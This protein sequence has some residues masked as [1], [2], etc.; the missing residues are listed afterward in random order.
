MAARLLQASAAQTRI[1]C[2]LEWLASR[3]PGEEILVL[4]A[5]ADAANELLRSAA[6][7]RGAAFGWHRGTLP[8]LAAQLAAEALLERGAVPVGRLA[9]QAVVAHVLHALDASG[10]AGR[11]AALREGPGLA[12]ALTA[13]LDELRHARVDPAALE[14]E[15][16]E[17]RAVCD[18]YAAALAAAGLADR[19]DVF[20]LAARRARAA[21]PHALL[22][23]PT[24]L[25]DVALETPVEAAL[26]AALTARSPELLATVPAGD[27]AS[28]LALRD[29]LGVDV[30]A[31]EPSGAIPASLA[32]LQAHLF[33]DTAPSQLAL[34]EEIALLSAP[35]ESRECVE[36]ARR[37]LGLA[38][39]GVAFDRIAILLR[40]PEEYRPHLV[41]AL[42]RAGIPAHFARGAQHPDAAGRAFLALLACAAEGLSARR[43]AEYLSLGEVPDPGSGGA[44]P[45]A[46]PPG[47]RWV[48]PDTELLAEAVAEALESATGACPEPEAAPPADADAPVVAGDLRAPRRWE[49]LLVDAAVIGGRERWQRRIDGLARELALDLEALE[50]PDDPAAERIRRSLSDLAHLRAYALPLLDALTALPERARWSAWLDRLAA[51]AT[52]ALRRPERVLAVL[53]EL[54]PMHEVGPVDLAEVRLVLARRLL[55]LAAPPASARYGRVFVAPADAARGLCFD[56]VFVPGLA[57]KLFPRKIQEEPLLLDA[58]RARLGSALAV[59]ADRVA[60]ERRALRLAV[61]AASK[62]LVLSYP[63]LDPDQ[64]RPRVP[65]FYALEALRA[66]EGRLPGFDELAQRAETHGAA[67]VGWPAP[68]RAEDAID[69]AEHDLALLESLLHLDAE[70]SVGTARYLLE[71][72]PHL[73]RALRFR[74]RRWLESWTHADGLIPPPRG[75]LSAAAREAIDAHA[76]GARSFSATALQHFAACPY[77]FFLYAVH[78]LAPREVPEAIETLDPLQRGSLVHEVQFELFEGLRAAGLL[79]VIPERL[80]AAREMLDAVLDGV[81][82]RYRE[83]L[84]PAIDRVFEDGVESVRADLRE[85]L[86]RAAADDSGYVPWRFELSFGL[87]GRRARD[88]HSREAPVALDCGIALRGAI[89]LLERSASGRIRATDHKT[90]AQRVRDG[91]VVAGGTALQPV[92]YALAAEKLFP[93]ARVDAGRLYYCTATG[94]FAERTVPLDTRA[95]GCADTLAEVIGAALAEPFLPAAPDTGA[96]RWCDYQPVC[97]PYEEQRTA[98]KCRAPLAPLAKLRALP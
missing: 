97:G 65:S 90:G 44:P 76:L 73:G 94:G 88:P 98:R 33:E 70:R 26:L 40:S 61:G 66:A 59:N 78:R 22:G 87:A 13:L 29:A 27:G 2:A 83:D 64:S 45:P 56:A 48:P 51:L 79:P 46:A 95:R 77:R 67:R 12:R 71:A 17:L 57:E 15:A 28:E 47:E 93:E 25:L 16:P 96:C 85:W 37:I 9:A 20:A 14:K 18:A 5:S 23:L 52:R 72:N 42:R 21:P 39:E 58:A 74:A 7:E 75:A 89:D 19:A 43:F 4:A 49:Q 62:H 32:R 35:G 24:L 10:A 34:G 11:F 54:A 1:A 91:Q 50:D 8:R 86:R 84:A 3:A 63:R 80:A 92:L 55:A 38:R 82:A 69:E 41:E 68:P 81:A 6:F 60:R 31:R 36:I 30:E 53:A